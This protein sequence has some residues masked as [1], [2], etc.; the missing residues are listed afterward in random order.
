[1][2]WT[3]GNIYVWNLMYNREISILYL[4]NAYQWVVVV[5]C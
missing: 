1:M 5:V 4:V 3:Y 2:V